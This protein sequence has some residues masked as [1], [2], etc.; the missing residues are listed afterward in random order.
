MVRPPSRMTISIMQNTKRKIL[1][2]L[3]S[4]LILISQSI[5][6]PFATDNTSLYGWWSE[7]ASLP[8]WYWGIISSR[9][10]G[11]FD[12]LGSELLENIEEMYYS[13]WNKWVRYKLVRSL[14]PWMVKHLLVFQHVF[15]L[16][17]PSPLCTM[18][19]YLVFQWLV[20][21]TFPY[22]VCRLYRRD[23][24]HF[25]CLRIKTT[26]IIKPLPYIL[27]IRNSEAST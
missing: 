22:A 6:N 25:V 4:R 24:Q 17:I 3:F 8:I 13:H 19:R 20:D 12:L 7:H 9:F 23:I 10:S 27:K 14:S 18:Q 1:L 11:N 15:V 16:F 21:V 26:H 2:L 5:F